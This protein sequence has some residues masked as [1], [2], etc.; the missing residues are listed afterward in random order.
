MKSEAPPID[1][2]HLRSWIG[3]EEVASDV[4]TPWICAAFRA[5]L[6]L[7][8]I[9]PA[10]GDAAP[11]AIHW[12]LAQPAVRMRDMGADGHPARGG[13]LPDVPLPRRMW[14]GGRLETKD[15][16]RVGDHVT[17]HSRI[18]DV[19]LKEGRS[20]RLCFVIV[21]HR[22]STQRGLALI[23]RQDIVYR[24]FDSGR[25]AN[26]DDP[27]GEARPAQWRRLVSADP[28]LLFRYSALTFNGHRIHYDR[29]YCEEV[30]GYPGLIVHGPLQATLLLH[31][32]GE[33]R[34]GVP[35]RDF[36]F[37][38]VR[39]LFDGPSFSVNARLEDDGL[40]LWI[41]DASERE[42]MKASARW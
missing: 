21:E 41:A 24:D 16:I 22:I 3:R 23:E 39:P 40:E 8:A 42:T 31:L 15:A 2:D 13:F 37:R 30:E 29:R 6:D 35:P 9:G 26:A 33:T 20:G 25:K 18:V 14:A 11:P 27:L 10:A 5:T 36:T 4:L 17:R 28:V 34:D 38:G 19:T 7:E 12:V 32:A 1:I